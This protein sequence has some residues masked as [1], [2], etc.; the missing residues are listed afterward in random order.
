MSSRGAGWVLS[1]PLAVAK[2]DLGAM[3]LERKVAG[4]CLEVPCPGDPADAVPLA[5]VHL[6]GWDK[7][8]GKLATVVSPDWA[9]ARV[10]Q[11]PRHAGGGD[12]GRALLAID[13]SGG[14]RCTHL[15]TRWTPD[16]PGPGYLWAPRRPAAGKPVT[17]QLACVGDIDPGVIELFLPS[18]C[19]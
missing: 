3:T 14:D 4:A 1:S 7:D 11:S 13:V 8:F 18:W 10:S 16:H 6:L 2:H 17:G 12:C 19:C 5:G 9:V 15:A